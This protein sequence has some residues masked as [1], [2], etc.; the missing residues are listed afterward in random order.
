MLKSKLGAPE[1]EALERMLKEWEVH[2]AD[3]TPTQRLGFTRLSKQGRVIIK[4]GVYFVPRDL[5]ED[6]FNAWFVWFEKALG[7]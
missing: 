6:E 3:C 7:I 5:T 4:R 1:V 2:R